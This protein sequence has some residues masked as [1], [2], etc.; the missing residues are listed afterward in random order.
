MVDEETGKFYDLVDEIED[1]LRQRKE[2]SLAEIERMSLAK[3]M[4][5]S[6][7]LDDISISEEFTVDLAGGKVI[8]KL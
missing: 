5:A 8:Y 3:G 7:I 1:L 6:A 2:L 4:R